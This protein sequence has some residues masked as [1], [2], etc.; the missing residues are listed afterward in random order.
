MSMTEEAT[1]RRTRLEERPGAVT[2][3][4][5]GTGVVGVLIEADGGSGG[6]VLLEQFADVFNDGRQDDAD[7]AE[8]AGEEEELEQVDGQAAEQVHAGIL[9]QAGPGAGVSMVL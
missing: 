7:G 9:P 6:L 1:T 8:H 3:F 4:V 5:L 2:V